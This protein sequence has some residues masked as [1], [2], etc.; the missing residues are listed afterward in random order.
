MQGGGQ[1]LTSSAQSQFGWP[2]QAQHHE[3]EEPRGENKIKFQRVRVR[4][5]RKS[6]KMSESN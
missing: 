1:R 4:V 5:R 2:N 6:G 3:A